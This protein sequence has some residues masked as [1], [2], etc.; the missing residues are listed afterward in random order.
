MTRLLCAVI[1]SGFLIAMAWAHPT[2]YHIDNPEKWLERIAAGEM[3]PFYSYHIH[4][5]FVPYEN[6]SS[7]PA[8][9]FR[10]KLVEHFQ[11]QNTKPCADLDHNPG[12]CMFGESA[13]NTS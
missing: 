13:A 12:V 9:Q 1:A 3:P 4:C 7:T 6:V 11:L 8:L 10:Q 5:L 2:R